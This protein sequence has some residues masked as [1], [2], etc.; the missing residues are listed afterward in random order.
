MSFRSV[1]AFADYAHEFRVRVD[2]VP[3]DVLAFRNAEP[4]AVDEF[5]QKPCADLLERRIFQFGKF[6][7]GEVLLPENVDEPLG[8]FGHGDCFGGVLLQNLG[9][10]E[11]LAETLQRGEVLADACG[12]KLLPD[13]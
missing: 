8:A 13:L 1:R 3:G 5:E 7:F 9:T 2:A 4:R 11:I 10:H 12:G 6:F